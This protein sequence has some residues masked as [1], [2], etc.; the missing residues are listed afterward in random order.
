VLRDKKVVGVLCGRCPASARVQGM[1][2]MGCNSTGWQ[3]QLEALHHAAQDGAGGVPSGAGE[4]DCHE[5]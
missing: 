4:R 5:G 3:A 1:Q 2:A